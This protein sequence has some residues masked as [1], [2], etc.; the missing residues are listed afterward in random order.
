MEGRIRKKHNEK[1]LKTEGFINLIM[2]LY[3]ANIYLCLLPIPILLINKTPG[4]CF[5]A[6]LSLRLSGC[7][8]LRRL[9]SCTNET[10]KERN[11]SAD[12]D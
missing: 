2:Q 3:W 11:S 5:S 1:R 9:F 7:C 4:S 8:Y 6:V 12:L 10:K